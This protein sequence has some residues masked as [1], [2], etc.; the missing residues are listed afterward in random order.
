MSVVSD[1]SPII[2]LARIGQLDLLRHLYGEVCVPK[3][4]WEELVVKGKGQTGAKKI[5]Q[6]KWIKQKEVSKH[7]LVKALR[8]ELDAGEAEAIALAI[9][10]GAELLL[11][12]DKI[13]RRV[14]Q[15]LNVPCIGTVGVLMEAKAKG[16]VFA[17]KPILD[18][19]RASGFYLSNE[20]YERVLEDAGEA[21]PKR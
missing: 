15:F 2:H 19:L 5:R 17:I 6:A 14:A 20:L 4:V 21:N 16:L 18:A 11:M 12:D 7:L 1:A 13:G 3:A 9:E 8:R 10:V